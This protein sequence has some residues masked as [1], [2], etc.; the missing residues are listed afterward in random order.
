LQAAK[1]EMSMEH[2]TT[3]LSCEADALSTEPVCF[4]QCSCKS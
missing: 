1:A 2:Q 3:N 4:W